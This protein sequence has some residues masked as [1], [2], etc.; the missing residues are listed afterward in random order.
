M[1]RRDDEVTGYSQVEERAPDAHRKYGKETRKVRDR[2]S[3]RLPNQERTNIECQGI[4]NGEWK[5]KEKKG[6]L[7]MES[8]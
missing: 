4:F 2:E 7:C 8:Q 5:G 6:R 3:I 1:S